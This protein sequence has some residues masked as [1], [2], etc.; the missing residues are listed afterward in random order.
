MPDEP[1]TEKDLLSLEEISGE[2]VLELLDRA[3]RLRE[4]DHGRPLEGRSAA[5][6]FLNPSLRTRT[7]FEL[8]VEK[9]GGHAV[10]LSPGTDAWK[11]EARDGTV[12]DGDAAEHVREAA[13][14]LGA[15]CDV[16][17]VRAFPKLV[18]WE[19]DRKETV[20]RAFARHAPV[21]VV[22]MESALS[23]PLQALADLLTLRD[24]LGDLAGR[25]LLLTFAYHPRP[26]PVAVPR[27]VLLAACRMG[28]RV[29]LARPEGFDLPEET[30]DRARSFAARAGGGLEVVADPDAGYPGAEAVYAKSWASPAFYGRFDMERPRREAVRDWIVTGERM[31]RTAGNAPFLHCLPVR[32]NVVVADEVLDG[33]RSAVIPQAANR[34]WTTMAV[35]DRIF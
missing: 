34:L 10:V 9:L 22:N 24:A 6:V 1:R 2:E 8:A 33:P 29:T 7:S 35:L 3:A 12:M 27:S 15:L 14:V 26:L 25:R 19:E 4:G 20:L 17:G 32:R 5:L 13:G 23:H 11:L 16:I 21:P 31:A 28:M 18:S 30:M